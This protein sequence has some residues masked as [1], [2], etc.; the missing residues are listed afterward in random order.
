VPAGLEDVSTFP[1]LTAELI[2]RGYSDADVEKVTGRNVLRAWRQMELVAAR[3]QKARG[4][5]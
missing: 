4:R 2:R 3:L 1:A 5:N